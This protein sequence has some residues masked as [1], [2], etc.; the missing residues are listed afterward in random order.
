MF[1]EVFWATPANAQS[2]FWLCS[3]KSLVLRPFRRTVLFHVNAPAL[4]YSMF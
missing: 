3:Q 1:S 4:S 2:Y